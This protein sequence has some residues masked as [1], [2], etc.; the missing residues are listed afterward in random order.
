MLCRR[1]KSKVKRS[2][3]LRQK[4]I[5]LY[6]SVAHAPFFSTGV[7]RRISLAAKDLN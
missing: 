5:S 2:I 4:G 3:R 1:C 7:S 6:D